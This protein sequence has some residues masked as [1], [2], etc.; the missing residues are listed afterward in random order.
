MCN[1]SWH[2]S[3]YRLCCMGSEASGNAIP[4]ISSHVCHH[5]LL[6]LSNYISPPKTF[7]LRSIR[8]PLV[9]REFQMRCRI[10]QFQ[11]VLLVGRLTFSTRF[12]TLVSVLP[13]QLSARLISPPHHLRLTHCSTYFALRRRCITCCQHTSSGQL[14][15]LMVFL[16]LCYGIL[17][18]QLLHLSLHSLTF[19]LDLAVFPLTG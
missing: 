8:C 5:Y 16:A 15:A 7:G 14:Q 2:A 17:P 3:I 11:P 12:S 9:V 6:S 13:L 18:P 1:H 4:L 19:L 10:S